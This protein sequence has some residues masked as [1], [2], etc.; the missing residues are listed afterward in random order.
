MRSYGLEVMLRKNEGQ[1]TGWISYTLSK[2]QQQTPGRNASETGINNGEWYNS[3]Y[4]KTHNVAVTGNYTLTKKWSFGANFALQTGQPVT[5]PTSYY[6]YRGINVPSYGLRNENRLPL[7]HHLDISATLTPHKNA[8]RNWKSEWVFSIYNLYGR[9][10]AASIAFRENV[11]TGINEAVKT[12]I[13]GFIPA[14]SYNF[15]F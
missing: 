7:Y 14:V 10:N 15:K 1:L 2:S 5:Y 11:D 13:F 8:N 4:D 6:E 3:L 12:S 9:K